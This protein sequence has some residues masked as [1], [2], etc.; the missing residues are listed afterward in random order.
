MLN[1]TCV[2]SQH[3]S[4]NSLPTGCCR[5]R[6]DVVAWF[7]AGTRRG[8]SK[9]GD[10]EVLLP[11]VGCGDNGALCSRRLVYVCALNK[12]TPEL[13]VALGVAACTACPKPVA[14]PSCKLSGEWLYMQRVHI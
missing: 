10:E 4:P 7:I 2:G 12:K 1:G 13:A 9:A 14:H 3:P 11:F 8:D 6:R 5:G